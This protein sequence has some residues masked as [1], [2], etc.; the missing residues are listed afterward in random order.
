MDT[1]GQYLHDARIARGIDL[2]D[3]AQQTRISIQYL[4]ALEEEDFSKLPGEVFVKGF[5]KS[6]GKFLNLDEAEVIKKYGELRQKPSPAGAAVQPEPFA[7]AVEH[8]RSSKISVEPFIWGAGILAV[9]ILFLFTALPARHPKEVR[10]ADVPLPTG[11][12]ELASGPVPTSKPEKL[13]LEVIA[14]EN[15]WLL[16]RTDTSPQKKAVLN[17]GESL[18]WSADESFMLSYG[19][20]SAIKLLLNGQELTVNEPKNAVIRDLA[21]TAS[22]IVSHKIQTENVKSVNPRRLGDVASRQSQT[23]G[24]PVVEPQA[25]HEPQQV[26]PKQKQAIESQPSQTSGA[27]EIEQKPQPAPLPQA[28][29]VPS[30]QP[31]APLEMLQRSAH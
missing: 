4:K 29:Q 27:S 7:P 2:R 9:L 21:I 26:S 15:T 25:R 19:S 22:G 12:A 3:A 18:I 1:L 6:Y 17:K 11:P 31:I 24:A 30:S 10:Q 16:V 13:Y 8:K 5:L 20:A 28:S 23:S 14:L